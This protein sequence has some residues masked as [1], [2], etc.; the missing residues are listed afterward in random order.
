MFKPVNT[1]S[2]PPGQKKEKEKRKKKSNHDPKYCEKG[3]SQNSTVL[4]DK[5]KK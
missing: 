3:L 2:H 4:N 1:I 5:N